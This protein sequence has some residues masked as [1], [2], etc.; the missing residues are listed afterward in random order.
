VLPS[1]LTAASAPWM[2][3]AN[4][5]ETGGMCRKSIC[6]GRSSSPRRNNADNAGESVSALKAEIAMANAMVSE[7]WR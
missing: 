7:N 4:A 1:Q 5:R 6:L 2:N 3:P